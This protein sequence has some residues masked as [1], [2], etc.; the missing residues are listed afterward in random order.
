[1][2]N[3]LTTRVSKLTAVQ[4]MAFRTS[5]VACSATSK[6][7]SIGDAVTILQSKVSQINQVV[8]TLD[9]IELGLPIANNKL[10]AHVNVFSLC[11]T[12]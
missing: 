9:Q 8:S 4:Q 2:F 12:T 10:F 3:K 7:P 5:A 1:M 6:K 11:R